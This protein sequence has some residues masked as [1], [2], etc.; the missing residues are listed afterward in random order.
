MASQ[1]G[2]ASHCS[3]SLDCTDGCGK[4]FSLDHG[5]NCPNGGSVIRRH[6][7]IRD[8]NGQLASLAYGHVTT[9]PV[10]RSSGTG[11]SDEGGL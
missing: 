5:L 10:Y 8:V 2:T 11:G 7:E 4:R 1:C 6:N 9:E 3:S